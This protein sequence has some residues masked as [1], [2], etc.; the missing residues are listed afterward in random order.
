[1]HDL[2][3]LLRTVEHVRWCNNPACSCEGSSER[4]VSMTIE[5]WHLYN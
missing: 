3:N 1:M 2:W 4:L 5:F